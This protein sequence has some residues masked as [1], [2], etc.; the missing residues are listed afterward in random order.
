LTD[1]QEYAARSQLKWRRDGDVWLLPCGRRR[2]GRV[3]RG[4][5]DANISRAKD[6]V[7]ARA[8]REVAWERANHPSK[9]PVKERSF[10][11]PASLMRCY[12]RVATHL[13][14]GVAD[15]IDEQTISLD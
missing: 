10:S 5:Y 9:R 4:M 3:T 1:E 15:Q 13:T 6:R 2:T 8:V 11:A 12:D 14:P 7:L